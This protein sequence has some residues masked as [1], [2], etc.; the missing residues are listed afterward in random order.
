MSPSVDT[1]VLGSAGMLGTHVVH[2]LE[3]ASFSRVVPQHGV[4]FVDP[5]QLHCYLDE[6]RP[7][8]VINCVGYLGADAAEHFRTNGCIPRAIA[9]W[10]DGRAFFV[11][12]STNA[13]FAPDPARQWLPGDPIRPLTAYEIAKAFGEDPRAYVLRASFVGRSGRGRNLWDRLRA[14]TPYRDGPYNGVTAWELALRIAELVRAIGSEPRAG[15][16]HVHAPLPT[17]IAELARLLG[18]TSPCTGEAD[19]VRLLGGGPA[20][21][22]FETQ[23]SEYLRVE[24]R[25]AALQSGQP[26]EG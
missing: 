15:F 10:C 26:S 14:G 6:I 11:H 25:I 21:G 17:R 1:V 4:H 12:V 18:S 2:A 20:R 7:G 9:D 19:N 3:Q 16:E 5:H 24:D 13:V 8:A 22:A 23:L